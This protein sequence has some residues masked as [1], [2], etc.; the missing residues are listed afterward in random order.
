MDGMEW[1]LKRTDIRASAMIMLNLVFK[2]SIWN[3]EFTEDNATNNI[4]DILRN[5][6]PLKEV[7][8]G[9]KIDDNTKTHDNPHDN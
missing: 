5:N 3:S 6:D 2:Q 7:G 1:I 4:C 8:F 9:A